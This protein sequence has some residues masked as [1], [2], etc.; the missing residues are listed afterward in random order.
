[1]D[2][3]SWSSIYMS[4]SD[5]AAERLQDAPEAVCTSSAVAQER[6]A[7][8][9]NED[10]S[11]HFESMCRGVK[12]TEGVPLRYHLRQH[13][14]KSVRVAICV[15]TRR[16]RGGAPLKGIRTGGGIDRGLQVDG[17]NARKTWTGISS[18]IFDEAQALLLSK[19]IESKHMYIEK[20]F[21]RMLFNNLF[22]SK[23]DID[24]WLAMRQWDNARSPGRLRSTRC[25]SAALG[26]RLFRTATARR[27]RAR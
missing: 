18:E 21:E 12:A 7:A 11:R 3:Q 13:P 19:R 23:C 24:A 6:I 17:R 20:E 9:M 5:S 16:P 4:L 25:L 1:M 27:A 2:P 15:V 8:G 10:R 22:V 26:F 14:Q